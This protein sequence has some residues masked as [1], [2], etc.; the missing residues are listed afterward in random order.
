MLIVANIN[1]T[2]N[3]QAAFSARQHLFPLSGWPIIIYAKYP[4]ML[5][6]PSTSIDVKAKAKKL[7]L[8]PLPYFTVINM[9]SISNFNLEKA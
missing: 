7:A 6:E 4:T 1:P 3:C 8:F 9:S 5:S 2:K